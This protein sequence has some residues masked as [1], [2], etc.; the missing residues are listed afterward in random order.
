MKLTAR[1]ERSYPYRTFQQAGSSRISAEFRGT[2]PAR[3]TSSEMIRLNERSV[4][5][6]THEECKY[7]E[8]F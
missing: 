5:P 6:M 1:D 7:L 8:F 3:S 4:D 2:P